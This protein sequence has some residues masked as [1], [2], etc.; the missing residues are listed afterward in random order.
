M[1]SNKKIISLSDIF[2]QTKQKIELDLDFSNKTMGKPIESLTKLFFRSKETD[3]NAVKKLICNKINNESN[4]SN[5][6]INIEL[7]DKKY[8][9]IDLSKSKI[10]LE[11][12]FH[13]ENSKIHKISLYDY[14]TEELINI[15]YS[16]IDNMPEFLNLLYLPVD[17]E[18]SFNNISRVS[19]IL[20]SV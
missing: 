19:S 2:V 1:S 4:A 13:S 7:N 16:C 3:P 11:Y 6:S 10:F 8:D 5:L 15:E 18:N 14:D 12:K 17:S 9:D 20:F